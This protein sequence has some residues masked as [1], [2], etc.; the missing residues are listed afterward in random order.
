MYWKVTYIYWHSVT[1]NIMF[2]RADSESDA[3][4][5]ADSQFGY[6]EADIKSVEEVTVDEILKKTVV[7]Y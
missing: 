7:G 6:E 4:K 5:V 1:P 2:V 3:W